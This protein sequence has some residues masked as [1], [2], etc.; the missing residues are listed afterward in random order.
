LLKSLCADN[1][2]SLLSAAIHLSDPWLREKCFSFTL[3]NLEKVSKTRSFH[4][5]AK[6]H[7]EVLVEIVQKLS[8][9]VYFT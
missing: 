9:L 5:M 6:S 2:A 7:P 1:A 4:E 8:T 3:Q